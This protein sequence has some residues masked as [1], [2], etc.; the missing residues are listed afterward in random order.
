MM[1]MII[2][3]RIYSLHTIRTSNFSHLSPQSFYIRPDNKH[4]N[5]TIYREGGRRE[6]FPLKK[7]TSTVHERL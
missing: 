7:R 5:K 3:Q 6:V 2:A 1:P 4:I